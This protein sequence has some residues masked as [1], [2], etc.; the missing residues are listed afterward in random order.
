M[1]YN[2]N[3][4]LI[5]FGVSPYVAANPMLPFG[6][7]SH[8]QVVHLERPLGSLAP[9][10]KTPNRA[11][12]QFYGSPE[13]TKNFFA[14]PRPPIIASPL[15]PFGNKSRRSNRKSSRSRSRSRRS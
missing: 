11:P 4:K 15:K 6:L 12:K 14:I 3:G 9:W 10:P 2:K 7:P 13:Q 5:P 8:A 1:A